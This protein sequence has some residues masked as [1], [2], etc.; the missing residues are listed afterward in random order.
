M[1]YARPKIE[2]FEAVDDGF[3]IAFSAAGPALDIVVR[4]ILSL[5]LWQRRWLAVDRVWW[6]A[7]DAISRLARRLPEVEQALEAWHTRPIRI[8]DEVRRH[9]TPQPQT[10]LRRIFVPRDVAQAYDLLGLAPGAP[11]DSVTSARRR[12]ARRH[13]PDAG[14]DVAAMAAINIAAD[15]VTAWL[16]GHSAVAR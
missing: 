11:V 3:L 8:E 2:C 15:T 14:G 12:L 9:T 10:W 1:E 7:D 16:E 6:I 13:H 4:T 5:D